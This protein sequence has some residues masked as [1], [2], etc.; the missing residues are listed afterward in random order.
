[1]LGLVA[2][3]LGVALVP[4]SARNLGRAGVVFR[5]LRDPGPPIELAAFW[6]R[7]HPSPALR[8]FLALLPEEPAPRPAPVRSRRRRGT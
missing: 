1:M 4:S 6:R 7:E 5:E 8:N 3:G 2:A